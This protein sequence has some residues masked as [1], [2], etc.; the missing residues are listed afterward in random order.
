MHAKLLAG[1]VLAGLGAGLNAQQYD[2][3]GNPPLGTGGG[4]TRSPGSSLSTITGPTFPSSDI[5]HNGTNLLVNSGYDGVAVIYIVNDSTGATVG[6]VPINAVDD[7]AC[8]W[9]AMR[10]LYISGNPA[11]HTIKTF[12][13]VSSTP[14]S[15]F[16]VP[17]NPVGV[18]WD[19]NRDVY[20]VVD[21]V[22]SSVYSISPV[23]GAVATSYST[24]ALGCTR[25]AGCGFDPANDTI[26][27]GGRDQNAIFGIRASN[28]TL[29]C[30]FP[31]LDGGNNP[32]GVAVETSRRSVWEGS[33]NSARLYEL[34]GCY[35]PPGLSLGKSG[36]CPGAMTFTA[37][38]ATPSGTVAFVWGT[39]GS[40][41][42][43]GGYPCA[44]TMLGLTP[45]LAPPPGYA[46]DAADG[47]GTAVFSVNV[48]PVGCGLLLQAVDLST[49]TTTNV[50]TL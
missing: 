46:L 30:S 44:G 14:V 40:F 50:V 15:T 18:A 34:E 17:G 11:A 42:I 32:Q 20:W 29:V 8:G 37:T 36:T 24:A 10:G 48:P 28:G 27:V 33:W 35:G 43:P 19:S 3:S 4:S 23:T 21:W 12:D 38:G 13:G 2:A 1:L 31:A 6:T 39:S 9:D 26:Y 5:D 25:P 47:S 41:V 49:C 7:G 16:V 22:S 45:L